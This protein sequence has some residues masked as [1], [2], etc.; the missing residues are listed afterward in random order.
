MTSHLMKLFT[1][2][3]ILAGTITQSCG[4]YSFTGASIEPGTKTVNIQYFPNNAQIVAPIL[5]QVFTEKLQDK[6]VNETGLELQT[7]DEADL[8]FSGSI[9]TYSISPVASG[10]DDLA[11]GN[12]LTIGVRVNYKNTLKEEEWSQSFSRFQDFDRS[13]NLKDIE[14]ELIDDIAQQLVDDIFNKALV[15]W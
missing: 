8:N 13:T 6:F 2:L 9:T 11:Y 12:R 3:F 5:S 14:D 7:N 1:M 10:G 4:I 15:N